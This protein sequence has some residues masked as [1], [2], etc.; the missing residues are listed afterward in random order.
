MALNRWVRKLAG[1]EP[2]TLQNSGATRKEELARTNRTMVRTLAFGLEVRDAGLDIVEHCTLVADMCG[3][4]GQLLRISL[5]DAYILDTAAR[6]H[7]IGMFSVPPD[8]LTRDAPL[9]EEEL[10]RVRS[11]ARLSAEI[12]ATMHHPRVVR[13]IEHQYVDY[14]ELAGKLDDQ[15]LLLAGIFRVADLIAAVTHP[16]PYQRPLPWEGRV[17]LLRGGAGT[18]F[19]PLVVEGALLIPAA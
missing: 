18:Q 19:H 8:L 6:L 2:P 9:S 4:L 5:A 1:A 11:Q 14:A 15:D 3:T 17:E 7:E 13:L 12:A 10:A 16:R